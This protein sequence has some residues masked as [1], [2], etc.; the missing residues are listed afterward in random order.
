MFIIN[1]KTQT[2]RI[3]NYITVFIKY[4]ETFYPKLIFLTWLISTSP[5]I[6]GL[7]TEIHSVKNTNVVLLSRNLLRW[8]ITSIN[9][10][11]IIS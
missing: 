11:K 7:I 10:T 2:Y 8:E 9:T 4:K 1:S 5:P 3:S 6:V